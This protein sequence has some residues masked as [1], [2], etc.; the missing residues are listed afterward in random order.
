MPCRRTNWHSF[1]LRTAFRGGCISTMASSP[2]A[3][4]SRRLRSWSLANATAGSEPPALFHFRD[5][6]IDLLTL[7]V[8][9][10]RGR[11]V[12]TEA[13]ETGA[14]VLLARVFDALGQRGPALQDGTGARLSSLQLATRLGLGAVGA[15]LHREAGH[16]RFCCL[17]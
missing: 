2:F 1:I 3:A 6:A 7:Q 10:G 14:I 8:R 11:I 4:V 5:E 15:D 16:G 17:R 12:R 13:G 9:A